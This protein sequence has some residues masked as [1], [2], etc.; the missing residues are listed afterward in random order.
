MT[1]ASAAARAAKEWVRTAKFQP[2]V[3]RSG[4]GMWIIRQKVQTKRST[5]AT[6]IVSTHPLWT[7]EHR[8]HLSGSKV[9]SEVVFE[10][11]A[12]VRHH[13]IHK[14]RNCER[15]MRVD[16]ADARLRQSCTAHNDHFGPEM[17]G[18][19]FRGFMMNLAPTIFTVV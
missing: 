15:N 1:G 11:T 5:K 4:G 9:K 13:K 17:I 18:G 2:R 6:E 14:R 10:C 3:T 16:E 7:G 19:L 12:S 8:S